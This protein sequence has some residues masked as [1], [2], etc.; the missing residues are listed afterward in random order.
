MSERLGEA[1]P[2]FADAQPDEYIREISSEKLLTT[3]GFRFQH[4]DPMRFFEEE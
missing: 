4:P 2:I 3:T 1:K